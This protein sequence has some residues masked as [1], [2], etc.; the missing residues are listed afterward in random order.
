M[1]VCEPYSLF[2]VEKCEEDLHLSCDTILFTGMGGWQGSC[3][4]PRDSLRKNS[5]RTLN[6]I[7]RR[8]WFPKDYR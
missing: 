7:E 5:Q 1:C 2:L 4:G 8:E 3:T 6:Y